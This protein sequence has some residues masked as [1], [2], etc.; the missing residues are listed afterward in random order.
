MHFR[1]VL[2]DGQYWSFS[3]HHNVIASFCGGSLIHSVAFYRV[4][5]KSPRKGMPVFETHED[6]AAACVALVMERDRTT[7]VLITGGRDH[8]STKLFDLVKNGYQYNSLQW[9][10]E[11]SSSAIITYSNT[12]STSSS[13]EFL[14]P[15]SNNYVRYMHIVRNRIQTGS[16][17]I[18]TAEQ[19]KQV[20]QDAAKGKPF[21]VQ[22]E[23]SDISIVPLDTW[24]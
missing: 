9:Y 1:Y 11:F 22:D 23:G 14:N 17:K 13:E 10:A 4:Q 19:M 2:K 15:N 20:K 12:L 7:S 16:T 3:F 5:Y 24:S 6:A 21:Y 8:Y 18:P